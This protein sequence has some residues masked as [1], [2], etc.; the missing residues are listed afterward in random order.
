M[1]YKVLT[2]MLL[3]SLSNIDTKGVPVELISSAGAGATVTRTGKGFCASGRV[4]PD[5]RHVVFAGNAADLVTNPP[6]AFS[7]VYWRD[8]ASGK[9][10][11]VSVQTNGWTGGN[12][13]SLAATI[14]S[15]G[16]WVAFASEAAGL[17]AGDTNGASDIFLRDL[18]T[19]A[20]TL[21][22][23]GVDGQPGNGPSSNPLIS[24][25][26]TVV[27]FESLA[28][29]LAGNDANGAVDVFARDL[30]SGKTRL[31]SVNAAG[32][33]SGQ[34]AASLSDITP[35]GRYVLF[36]S[37]S[38]DLAG[39]STNTT[40]EV[41]LRD[42][43]AQT[44]VWLSANAATL[45]PGS[46][47]RSSQFPAMSADGRRVAFQIVDSQSLLCVCHDLDSGATHLISSNALLH[48]LSDGTPLKWLYR[49][50]SAAPRISADGRW[51]AYVG[52]SLGEL[53]AA[54]PTT[55]SFNQVYLWD[56]NTG[57]SALVS[58]GAD[59]TSAGFGSSDSPAL[60]DDGKWAVFVS[61]ATNLTAHGFGGTAQIYLRDLS[62]GVTQLLSIDPDE[63]AAAAGD[64]GN[65]ELSANGNSLVFDTC[66]S[67]SGADARRHFQD[68]FFWDRSSGGFELVSTPDTSIA[69]KTANGA[70]YLSANGLSAGAQRAV[71]V[72]DANNLAAGD[73]NA[74]RNL[75]WRDLVQGTNGP[76][77][78]TPAMTNAGSIVSRAPVISDNGQYVAFASV[79]AQLAGSDT[80]NASDVF[81]QDLAT[82][83]LRLI[84]A[85]A[86][87]TRPGNRWSGSPQF[88]LD[89]GSV[90]YQSLATDLLGVSYRVS[91]KLAYYRDGSSK[92]NV[93]LGVSTAGQ[94]LSA[95]SV[96]GISSALN[97]AVLSGGQILTCDLETGAATNLDS[98][99]EEASLSANGQWLVYAYPALGKILLHNLA[100]L[101]HQTITASGTVHHPKVSDD[102]AR[103][104]FECADANAQNT[105]RQILVYAAD[106]GATTAASV[107]PEGTF[108]DDD[109]STSL[110]SPEGRWVVFAS[111]A[112]N[113][114]ALDNNH[115]SDV[116]ARDLFTQT[117]YCLSLNRDGTGTGN[118]CSA[119]PVLSSD[120]GSVGFSSDAS[121]LIEGD[122]NNAAD[123]F[124]ARLASVSVLRLLKIERVSGGVAIHWAAVPGKTYQ[125]EYKTQL[126]GAAWQTLP[127]AVTATTASAAKSDGT[128]GASTQRYYRIIQTN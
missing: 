67:L 62:Q 46:L 47:K 9:T 93:L 35:D 3:Y 102:G 106:T 32:T 121:D 1:K 91:G 112:G 20:T 87:N 115:Q 31:V 29:N 111:L 104:V 54:N 57:Q 69:S 86:A 59:G 65:L 119:M 125:I 50:S 110:L 56:A 75:F 42:L 95:V 60:S 23:V 64:F 30:A 53:G 84:S 4:T 33:A 113:L 90:V 79:S 41:Y 73:T 5:G 52:C 99:G 58:V 7:Q 49:P 88:C 124:V 26:G 89:D 122:R 85:N 10:R 94:P 126:N 82:G 28:S 61:V 39:G 34:S 6:T 80:N 37:A 43:T 15:N 120:G 116:F 18:E 74:A 38:A 81:L 123:V 98:A 51:V 109:S 100:N 63:S 107:S 128:L 83:T 117:T 45:L 12:G 108:G 27:A 76:V 118:G 114:V 96:D 97:L 70:S 19:G 17:V 8:R 2:V 11:L 16:Q 92:R 14:S 25:S 21:L 127:G 22:S 105:H 13:H 24:Q 40:S 36:T 55:V 101:N 71:F 78:V 44:T 77:G 72:S 103:V 68:V 66:D 48:T